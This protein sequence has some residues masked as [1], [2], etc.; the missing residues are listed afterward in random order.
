M[1]CTNCGKPTRLGALFCGECGFKLATVDATS[2]APV[3]VQTAATGLLP[4]PPPPPAPVAE[5]PVVVPPPIEVAPFIPPAPV[6]A[7]PVVE[8][9]PDA[10]GSIVEDP[11][12]SAP[13]GVTTITP[14]PPSLPPLSPPPPSPA[15]PP[16]ESLDETRVSVRRRAGAH[17]RLVLP[18][19]KH[20]DVGGA[21]LVGRD[22][23]VNSTWPSAQLF[24]VADESH[25]V[26]KTHA[27]FELDGDGLWVTDLDSSN[28][29]IITQPDGTE[30]DLEPNVRASIQ[31]G[32]DV[33]LGDYVIQ[34]EK[35]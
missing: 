11:I 32:A 31:P 12:F 30:I 21:V 24:A 25:S 20:A 16:V 28:G 29:V 34:I 8:R 23:S 10:P 2:A 27:V 13:P 7:P 3:V 19:G 17:W 33:E 26:S 18:D 14:P 6:A 1:T 35:D 22:P 15:A 5:V 9:I 4:P